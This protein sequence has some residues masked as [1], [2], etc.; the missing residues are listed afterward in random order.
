MTRTNQGFRVELRPTPEQRKRLGQHAGLSRV[1]ENFCLELVKA[2][3]DQREAERTYGVP[4]SALTTAPWT[5]FALEYAWRRVHPDRFPWFRVAGLSSRV[6]KEACRMRAAGLRN[7]VNSRRGRRRGRRVGFPKWRKRK[8]GSRFRVEGGAAYP[9]SPRVIHLPMVGKVETREDMSWLTRRIA[10]GRAR[11]LSVTVREKADR[12]WVSFQIEIDRSDINER[13][14]VPADAPT[15][16]IDLGLKTF[17]TI[18]D[19]T[20]DVEEIPAPRALKAAQR[21][22]RKANKALSRRQAGSVNRAKARAAVAA[23]HLKVAHRRGDFLHQLTSR[24]ARTKRAIA[25][26]TLNVAGMVKNR[27]LARAISDAGFGQFRRMLEYKADWYGSKVWAADVWFPSSRLCSTCGM[28][29]AALTLDDRRWTC[30]CGLEHDRD[31][32]AARNLLTA[33]TLE[34]ANT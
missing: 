13:R 10:D 27:R 32:N 25:V 20:G 24:L 1:V 17:A 31:R 18:V 6:P 15:C 34:H 19:D 4:E 29:N 26:E 16:G 3:L 21:K 14:Q 22:L 23:I 30:P 28:V 12:W 5:A 2:A 33:M 8:D 11:V 7:W 9:T